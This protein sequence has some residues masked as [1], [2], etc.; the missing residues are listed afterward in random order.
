MEETAARAAWFCPPVS[1]PAGPANAHASLDDAHRIEPAVWELVPSPGAAAVAALVNGNAV[2][3][4][5]F[6][7]VYLLQGTQLSAR[8]YRP[9]APAAAA[10]AGLILQQ[11]LL[12]SVSSV[13][14]QQQASLRP[15]SL[16]L[17]PVSL[18]PEA[19][20]TSLGAAAAQGFR[21][22]GGVGVGAGAG[23]GGG[24]GG[25]GPF[26][27]ASLPPKGSLLSPTQQ[28]EASSADHHQQGAPPARTHA[29]RLPS[30]GLA[31]EQRIS[32]L[33][34]QQQHQHQLHQQ[35]AGSGHSSIANK[36][37]RPGGVP[38]STSQLQRSVA[39][40]GG[41]QQ[42]QAPPTMMSSMARAAAQT[43][44]QQQQQQEAAA[45]AEGNV[46][47]GGGSPP[48]P[49][50][51][52]GGGPEGGMDPRRVAVGQPP[53]RQ[54]HQHQQQHQ[55]PSAFGPIRSIPRTAAAKAHF[56]GGGAP[57]QPPTTTWEVFDR[58]APWQKQQQKQQQQQLQHQHKLQHPQQTLL[59][60]PS[61]ANSPS[62]TP[63]GAASQSFVNGHFASSPVEGFSAPQY[64]LQPTYQQ[65]QKRPVAPQ[66]AT[67]FPSSSNSLSAAGLASTQKSP[68]VFSSVPNM[69]VAALPTPVTFAGARRARLADA[70]SRVP[71]PSFAFQ[72]QQQ[73]QSPTQPLGLL[74]RAT[75]Q[76]VPMVNGSG[77]GRML[78]QQRHVEEWSGGG[79]GDEYEDQREEDVAGA[80]ELWGSYS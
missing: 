61:S 16:Q 70:G 3:S 78:Q 49:A 72:L 43:R 21:A 1:L 51:G 35:Q 18:R 48:M 47:G 66:R 50:G 71:S 31:G 36:Y 6:D 77:G 23:A 57:M 52:G 4:G 60:A 37:R 67:S 38:A 7:A 68:I 9:R 58:P 33:A 79:A 28:A 65:H 8:H 32:V 44:L 73:E 17:A 74:R 2:A 40:N 20:L 62:P 45:A 39:P 10:A 11:P 15:H 34:Q 19:T 26:T 25:P 12:S 24:G 13:Q 14:Q 75:T 64:Q 42:Q 46:V 59:V 69:T 56:A 30:G 27:L 76:V 54:Q 5:T 55:Q 22:G 63:P 80:E 29:P 41:G 53:Y